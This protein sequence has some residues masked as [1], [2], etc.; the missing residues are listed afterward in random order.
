MNA[1]Q[2][3]KN[4]PPLIFH[5]PINDDQLV[6]KACDEAL[7][8]Q[9][10]VSADLRRQNDEKFSVDCNT[11]SPH[12]KS[13]PN[14]T[15]LY[16][17]QVLDDMPKTESWDQATTITGTSGGTSSLE[18]DFNFNNDPS[19][20]FPAGGSVPKGK[21]GK[22]K[23]YNASGAVPIY[24]EGNFEDDERAPLLDRLKKI[25]DIFLCYNWSYT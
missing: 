15:A 17:Q 16:L 22:G 13:E 6:L 20:L 25:F 3:T 12:S 9:T 23:G 21:L 19:S 11:R 2:K 1:F 18:N 8:Q 4:C 7:P 24:M 14:N 10:L 5:L